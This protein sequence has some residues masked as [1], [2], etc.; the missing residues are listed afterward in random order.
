MEVDVLS[1]KQASQLTKLA[2]EE[3]RKTKAEA[4]SAEEKRVKELSFRE[5][6][7]IE[8]RIEKYAKLGETNINYKIEWIKY[9]SSTQTIITEIVK[10]LSSLGYKIHS[11]TIYDGQIITVSWED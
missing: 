1:A 11:D 3:L 10:Q 4:L 6:K 8:A 2:E 9:N 5:L 7:E